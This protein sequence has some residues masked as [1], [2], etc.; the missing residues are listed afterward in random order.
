M[1]A[2]TLL[3]LPLPVGAGAV[4]GAQRPNVILILTDDQ[5]FDEVRYMPNT[6]A[7][8]PTKFVNGF[9]SNAL[10]CPSRSTI[11]SGL[12]S[13]DNG[14]WT[15]TEDYHG[16]ATA[17]SAWDS[18]HDSLPEILQTQGYRTGLFGKFLNGWDGEIPS[19][20]DVF[21]T[22]HGG[23]L[24]EPGFTPYYDYTEMGIQDGVPIEQRYGEAPSDYSTTVL[25]ERAEGFIATAPADQPYFLYFA[26]SAPHGTLGSG[27]GGEPSEQHPPPIPAPQD[28]DAPVP[29]L[30]TIGPAFNERD[31]RDKPRWLRNAPLVDPSVNKQWLL[32]AVRSLYSVDR[33]VGDI[34][35]A[36]EAVDPGLGNT[37]IIFMSDNGFS[38]GA[39]RWMSKSVPYEEA[40][41]VP[42]RSYFPPRYGVPAGAVG[43]ITL[44]LD[45]PATIVDLAGGTL[46]AP[47]ALS[48]LD[49]AAR[50]SFVIEGA[51]D[52]ER[53]AYCGIRT[54]HAKFVKY[55]SGEVEFYNLARDPHE[56][57]SD[58]NAPGAD[59]LRPLARAGC[60]DPLPPG[61]GHF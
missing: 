33:E 26:P 31:M 9:V 28:V 58:P 4:L 48:I 25:G 36:A 53:R 55:R 56:L 27:R 46:D 57:E 44:N 50:N 12:Y 20:W 6:K 15:N 59:K 10:C 45:V 23:D 17:F 40:I 11:L 41:H 61:W 42:F 1:L 51:V 39:H 21:D 16:G 2:A 60:N 30:P 49:P 13:H 54:T 19:G 32:A 8:T 7:A 34:I 24:K 38:N 37:V 3:T 5:R 14:V 29:S 43:Q 18:T 35:A 22:Q 47:D 52:L